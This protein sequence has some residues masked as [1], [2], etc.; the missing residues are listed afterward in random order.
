MQSLSLSA[1]VHIRR[2]FRDFFFFQIIRAVNSSESNSSATNLYIVLGIFGGIL[3]IAIVVKLVQFYQK[4][5]GNNNPVTKT[6]NHSTARRVGVT[7][8]ID[9]HSTRHATM[10]NSTTS[11]IKSRRT[12]GRHST[13]ISTVPKDSLSESG[14]Q[15]HHSTHIS[16]I[17]EANVSESGRQLY[18]SAHLSTSEDNL[19][20][21]EGQIHHSSTIPNDNVSESERQ[22]NSSALRSI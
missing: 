1:L 7:G 4:N 2:H 15:I 19:A 12:S 14:R 5:P 13:H 3:L 22:A 17:P 18:H 11:N 9:A 16:T 10:S 20:E 8:N 21:S 6:K